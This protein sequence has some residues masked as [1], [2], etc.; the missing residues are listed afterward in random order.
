MV[1]YGRKYY[2]S[3]L[4][5]LVCDNCGKPF[6]LKLFH[7]NIKLRRGNKKFYCCFKCGRQ[8]PKKE[9]T[10]E[11]MFWSKVDK[12]P[13]LGPDGSCWEWRG[14]IQGRGYGTLYIIETRKTSQAHR[15]SYELHKGPIS[16][17]LNILHSCDNRKC[18]NPNHLSEGTQKDNVH[19]M[20]SKN[21]GYW[22]KGINL[23]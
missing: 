17:D 12:T 23:L 10:T 3:P 19:D 15:Y 8:A 2:R 6:E 11:I 20:M 9:E 22:Q 21:R 18:V 5:G 14:A 13:G 1:F 7:Y 16:T 4:V